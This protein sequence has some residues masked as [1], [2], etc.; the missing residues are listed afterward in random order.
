[1]DVVLD[2]RWAKELDGGW[3]LEIVH[4]ILEEQ[5]HSDSCHWLDQGTE[6]PHRCSLSVELC[7]LKHILASLNS[8]FKEQ[9]VRVKVRRP[10]P[11]ILG[12]EQGRA[13]INSCLAMHW[14]LAMSH[15]VI[16]Y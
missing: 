8:Q 10:W 1:M 5:V 12:Y 6:H 3:D 15:S 11:N 4:A 14:V 16:H 9:G 13:S 7:R 2:S